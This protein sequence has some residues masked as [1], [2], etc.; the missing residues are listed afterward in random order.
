M[1]LENLELQNSHSTGCS[2]TALHELRERKNLLEV[3]Q[4]ELTDTG[5]KLVEH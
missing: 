1:L 3:N 2:R 5:N 4:V